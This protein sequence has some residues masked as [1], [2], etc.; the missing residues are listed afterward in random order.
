MTKILITGGTGTLGRV[1]SELLTLKGIEHTIASRHNPDS[2]RN[3]VHLDLLKNTGVATAIDGQEVIFH[4]AHDLKKE[5]ECTKNLLD[6]LRNK[7]NTQLIYISIVGV[8]NIPI[9]YYKQKR[10]SEK[11]IIESGIPYSILRSTQ[12]HDFVDKTLTQI[13]KFPV[14]FLPKKMLL[15]PI[16]TEVTAKNLAMLLTQGPTGR[17]DSIGGKQRYTLSEL[18]KLWQKATNNHSFA[19]NL[20]LFGKFG[21]ALNEGKL[22]CEKNASEGLSWEEWLKRKY[23][24]NINSI[25]KDCTDGKGT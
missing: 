4:L 1:L 17:I 15:Q 23:N 8:D 16:Q 22:T 3:W 2:Q 11:M 19:F 25:N 24:M 12:F 7:S 18:L 21:K 20:P 5:N 9:G 13:M 14:F 10:Q 6:N